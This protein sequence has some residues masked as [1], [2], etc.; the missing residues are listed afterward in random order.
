MLEYPIDE[1][2]Q[3]QQPL[4][5]LGEQLLAKTSS[6]AAAILRTAAGVHHGLGP[7][8]TWISIGQAA[9]RRSRSTVEAMLQNELPRQVALLRTDPLAYF[10]DYLVPT[11]RKR[12]FSEDAYSTVSTAHIEQADVDWTTELSAAA[13]GVPAPEFV[14]PSVLM[15]GRV[16]KLKP[17]PRREGCWQVDAASQCFGLSGDFILV[18]TLAAEWRTKVARHVTNVAAQLAQ[19]VRQQDSQELVIARNELAAQGFVERDDL[20]FLPGRAPRL[21]YVLPAHHNWTLRRD[22]VRDLAMT[23]PLALPPIAYPSKSSLVVY[24]RVKNEWKI[25]TLPHGLCWGPDPPQHPQDSPGVGLA[26]FLRWAAVRIAGNGAFHSS[27]GAVPSTD[28]WLEVTSN[29]KAVS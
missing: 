6:P 22:S 15:L 17:Q 3:R 12:E 16:W 29:S 5:L 25:V 2:F 4:V 23:A 8:A 7:V 28:N 9:L 14:Q 20:L 11:F 27:D 1:A 18:R 19:K 13:E 24:Q 26:S 10:I 21:G